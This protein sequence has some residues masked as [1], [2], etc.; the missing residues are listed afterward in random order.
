MT[1]LTKI[2]AEAASAA[3]DAGLKGET[4]NIEQ[5]CPAV[6]LEIG[7]FFDGTLN[8]L[9][10]VKSRAL[11]DQSYQNA[12]SNPALLYERYKDGPEYNE[13]NACGGVDR[14]FRSIYV[15]GAGSSRNQPDDSKGYIFGMGPT[16]IEARVVYGFR[17]VL[18]EIGLAGGPPAIKKVVL[19]VFGF[20]R[21]AATARYF[22]NC[23]RNRMVM[24]VMGGGDSVTEYLPRDLD[25]EIRFLG[26]FDTVAAFGIAN[27]GI[28]APV[29][30]HLKT[31]QVTGRI[32]HLT[33]GEE[34]RDNFRLNR[35][36]P[37][38]GDT[39]ELP[40]AHSDIGGGYAEDGD[41]APLWD[42]QPRYF[43]SREKAEAAQA[44]SRAEDLESGAGGFWEQVFVRQGWLRANETE[45]G[46]IREITD[47]RTQ[48][49]SINAGL[50]ISLET[51]VY[52]YSQKY[53]LHRPWVKLGLSTVAL[54]MMHEA[55]KQHVNGALLDLP[56]GD[57]RY[58]I[59]AG[60]LPY[61]PA[62]KSGALNGVARTEVLRGYGHVSMKDGT[63][64]NAD[65]WGHSPSAFFTRIE[66][67]NSSWRAV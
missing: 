32:Y 48:T 47:I 7:V 19:D 59:P 18:D 8:N 55:A 5:N 15:E 36:I 2:D 16:G 63:V 51:E 31:E 41:T 42:D 49:E 61:V 1:S 33:A 67:D 27:N 6:T 35:N 9:Y 22:V 46:V 4:G 13:P 39:L 14:M 38:G 3:N 10:N 45:G 40:G 26:I 20:S 54:H 28:N 34:Y 25:V 21:G 17:Q 53:V 62:I 57:D 23:I 24:Y 30:I 44:A 65:Y 58:D 43:R 60:L 66:Y 52:S 64:F 37:G 29:N 12:L 11:P 56:V 50:G